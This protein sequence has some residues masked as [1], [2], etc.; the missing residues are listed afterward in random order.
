M[1][2]SQF[3][4]R[5]V[6]FALASIL[7]P[8]G[9]FA[10]GTEHIKANYTKYDYRIPMRDGVRLFTSVFVPK[11]TK[12]TYPIMLQRTPYG[13]GPYGVDAERANLGPSPLFGKAGYIFA[14]QDVRGAFLSEGD[15]VDMRPHRPNKKGPKEIDESSDTF[16]TVEWLLKNVK[17]HNGRVG[18]WGIS[19]PGT[20]AVHGMID[21]HPAMKA[22]SPQAPMIDWF[23]GD[24]VHHNGAFFLQQEFNFDIAFSQPRAE[25]TTKLKPPFDH[26]TPDAYQ[27]F[28][29]MGSLSRA[30]DLYF[31]GR[32]AFW[33]DVMKHPNYDSFWQERSLLP[34]L[35]DIKPAV[36]TV[37]GWFDAEDLFGPLNSFQALER[38][39]PMAEN[40]L[41]MGPWVHGGW[42]GSDGESL[43]PVQFNAKTSEN[44]RERIEFPFFEH[45]LKGQGD[46]KP[47]KA[48]IFETGRNRWLKL[49]S[50]P[51]RAAQHK[52][53]FLHTGGKLKF[54]APA[55][56]NSSAFDEF[57]S[58]PAKPVPYTNTIAIN[59]PKTFP[60]EDQRFAARR[61]DVLVYE[62]DI[63]DKDLTITGPFQANLVVST[64]GTDADWV[65]KLI[66]VYPNDYPNPKSNHGDVKMGGYQQLVRGDV[67]RGKFRNSFEKPEP[68]KPDEPTQVKFTLQDICHT[69][70][71]GHRI[72][73]QIQSTWFPL[74]DR[75]PQVF[76]DIY[77]AKES[78]YR[79]AMQRVYHSNKR[80]SRL[81][82]LVMP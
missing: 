5:C 70:R 73:V 44:Y 32:K 34:H 39:K 42:S 28:L 71:P 33:H 23:L 37:G 65:V 81:E 38:A 78:D 61:S 66:D 10:Q 3:A 11:N 4:I 14:Y 63:L 8:L 58:D 46:W 13:V 82:L 59:Y 29:R 80:A 9:A 25:P 54:E 24:D 35:K 68:F 57:V 41:V 69:F 12:T 6:L 76:L 36:L 43:G 64:S 67:M 22:V 60:I 30:D 47:A 20:Y 40:V 50:W 77:Q 75:N 62:S 7:V 19:Y 79:K 51:P 21:A 15:F 18:Q 1:R 17:G 55:N 48:F 72:M 45:H 56:N 31:K 49:D 53:L 74:V 52:T 26:G 16:D 27:F 2:F